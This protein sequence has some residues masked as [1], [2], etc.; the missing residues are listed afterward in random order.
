MKILAFIASI[1]MIGSCFFPWVFIESREI[2][3]TGVNTTGTTYGKPGYF[4]IFL[5][6]ICL[7][8][9]LIN[10]NIP[11][12]IAVFFA[13]FN[14]A[15]ALRNYSIISGCHMG[16]CPVK[17][18]AIYLIIIAAVLLLTATLFW[19]SPANKSASGTDINN[20]TTI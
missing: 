20:P 18:P 16:E 15:W 5:T 2:L 8:C 3:I 19:K 13:A 1:L 9:L 17:Q 11:H 14:V 12:K 6:G 10:K 4:H 7:I